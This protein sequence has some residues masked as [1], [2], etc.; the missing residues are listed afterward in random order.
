MYEVFV[1]FEGYSTQIDNVTM[2]AN[3]SCTLIKG[4][5]NIIIDTMTAWDGQSI[6]DA[7]TKKGL[8]PKDINY[9][10][11]SH[12]HADHIGN[13]SLFLEADE[14]IVGLTA[15]RNSLFYERD[16]KKRDYK[17]CEGVTV[18][19]TPGH[20]SEDVTVIVNGKFEEKEVTVAVTGDLFEKEEDIT[21]PSIWMELGVSDLRKVQASSRCKIASLAD[22][23]IPGHGPPFRVTEEIR[24]QLSEQ[25]Q[26]MNEESNHEAGL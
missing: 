11:C 19:A 7:L 15:H 21:D 17:L 4:P 26:C 6:L 16:M 14:H 22:V 23:I 18:I 13:N 2:D 10:V 24:N 3:C 12:S 1:L 20:T 5:K 25:L 9:V 8:Q